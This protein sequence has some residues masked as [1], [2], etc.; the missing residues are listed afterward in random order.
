MDQEKEGGGQ[1][2]GGQ[3]YKSKEDM[4]C[5]HEELEPHTDG[6]YFSESYKNKTRDNG[7]Y[8]PARCSECRKKLVQT[9]GLLG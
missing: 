2:G 5:N 9:I 7:D 6:A 3:Q 1:L 8:M 4:G